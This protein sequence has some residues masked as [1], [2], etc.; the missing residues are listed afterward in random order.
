MGYRFSI[1]QTN[2]DCGFTKTDSASMVY[3]YGYFYRIGGW[4]G[5]TYLTEVWKS[6]NG[7]TGWTQIAD[8]P[9]AAR[10]YA[11]FVNIGGVAYY[12]M[13]DGYTDLYRFNS[14]E[15]WT[16][17]SNTLSVPA[18]YLPNWGTDGT[19][20]FVCGGQNEFSVSAI[21]LYGSYKITIAGV[22]T[23]LGDLP[24]SLVGT[25]AMCLYYESGYG[26]TALG[27]GIQGVVEAGQ[28]KLCYSSDKM[29]TW[30]IVATLPNE[31]A[32]L[33]STAGKYTTC[34]S[35]DVYWCLISNADNGLR[36]S[37]DKGYTWL[38]TPNN[39][40]A[41]HASNWIEKSDEFFL[42]GGFN[43]NDPGQGTSNDCW[44]L[45]KITL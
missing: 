4:N 32:L 22:V 13:G 45:V 1:S 23:Q 29:L 30:N 17:I 33:H 2:S 6:A 21:A 5:N 27:G 3:I 12:G 36:Y 19:D 16:L 41:K 14:N 31:M 28:N 42:L 44:K 39:P 7:V 43:T 24:H 40:R 9:G 11:F 10:H 35:G 25:A 8:F 38:K 20:I 18:I 26:F 34:V 15:T 37:G